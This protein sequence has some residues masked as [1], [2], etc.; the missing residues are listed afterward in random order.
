MKLSPYIVA[1]KIKPKEIMLCTFA[2][3][4]EAYD[5][6]FSLDVVCN[7]INML[8]KNLPKESELI[9]IPQW[10]TLEPMNKEEFRML[11]DKAEEF[12][13]TMQRLN[14]DFMEGLEKNYL[15]YD[16]EF[17]ELDKEKGILGAY[18]GIPIKINET[19]D[20]GI[21]WIKQQLNKSFI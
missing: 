13:K 19:L 20:D 15:K 14:G 6:G 5:A 21:V 17:S 2:M 9:A 18:Q 11:L 10:M 1:K 16:V 7:F 12:Y 8:S 3:N 4:D